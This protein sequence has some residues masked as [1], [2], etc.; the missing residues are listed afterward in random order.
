M[1]FYH[2]N[3][4]FCHPPDQLRTQ[5]EID[6][7]VYFPPEMPPLSPHSNASAGNN[8][9]MNDEDSSNCWSSSNISNATLNLGDNVGPPMEVY[10]DELAPSNVDSMTSKFGISYTTAH[11][12]ETKLAKMLNDIQAPKSM[13]AAILQWGRD[14][15]S[16]GYDF[17]PR[18]GNKESLINS[19]QTQL[20]LEHFRPEKIEIQLPG[21]NLR[22][23]ITRF[24]FTKGL[25]SLLMHPDLTSNLDNLDVNPVDP[26]GKYEAPNGCVGVANSGTWYS[27]AYKTCIKDPSTDFLVPICFACDETKLNGGTTG[28]WPLMFSTTIFNQKLRNTA[29]AWRPLGYIY[30]LSIDE[31]ASIHNAQSSHLH[32]Q[33][34][35]NIFKAILEMLV[36]AQA[37][38]ALDRIELTLG[39]VTKTVNMHVPVNFIIGD[40]QGGDKICACSPCYSNKMQRLCRKCYVKGSDADNP[41]V[42]CR[43]MIMAHIQARVINGEFQKLDNINQY[44]VHNAWFD[45]D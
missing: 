29:V 16:H 14:A 21:D 22:V 19:L 31:S 12:I 35:H 24:N 10:A 2:Q 38:H 4:V 40:M 41:F 3:N 11:V 5:G 27:Q 18:H 33:R 32:Y 28:C 17:V 44:H 20:H 1:H 7:P 13:Y 15:Y 9:A 34:L 30:D 36:D 43:R 6:S 42:K 45:V 23:E 8:F 39:G 25:H 37:P 26:F